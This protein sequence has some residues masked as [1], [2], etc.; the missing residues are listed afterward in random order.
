MESL[1]SFAT[2]SQ[3][4]DRKSCLGAVS[5]SKQ[6]N[7]RSYDGQLS[8]FSNIMDGQNKLCEMVW[9]LERKDG[10]VLIEASGI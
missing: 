3:L 8:N 1:L 5:V 9:K 6:A 4:C 10:G 7:H 2:N